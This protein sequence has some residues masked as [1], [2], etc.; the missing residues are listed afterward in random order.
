MSVKAELCLQSLGRIAAI[1]SRRIQPEQQYP[2][3]K[4]QL[5]CYVSRLTLGISG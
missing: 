4:A 2:V 1:K 5:K 3:L